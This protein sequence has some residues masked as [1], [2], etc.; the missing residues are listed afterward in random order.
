MAIEKFFEQF[1]LNMLIVENALTIPMHIPLGVA[2]AE[3]IAERQIPT[4]AHHHDF[5]REHNTPRL[6]REWF[7]IPMQPAGQGRWEVV[8]GLDETGHF[9]AKCFFL[10]QGRSEPVWPSGPNTAI[11][12][13]PADT[14]CGNI[15]YNAFVR[16]F[17]PY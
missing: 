2:L 8:I 9:E 11:N 17:G 1:G 10:P 7:D 13:E 4:V 16:Q 5:F 12:V 6:G 14:C 3:I 15:I